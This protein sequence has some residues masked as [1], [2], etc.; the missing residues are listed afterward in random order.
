MDAKS[1]SKAELNLY[2]IYTMTAADMNMMLNPID[3]STLLKDT[4]IV[5][6]YDTEASIIY[7][8]N[9]KMLAKAIAKQLAEDG[10]I[11][12]QGD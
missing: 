8:A 2:T 4:S 11:P 9:V 6:V 3:V 1:Y 10:V 12:I 5:L 7:K